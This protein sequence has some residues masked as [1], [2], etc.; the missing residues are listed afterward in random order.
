M[1]TIRIK[2]KLWE[3]KETALFH[4]AAVLRG[5]NRKQLSQPPAVGLVQ[6]I[7]IGQCSSN[8]KRD[9]EPPTNVAIFHGPGNC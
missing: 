3:G 1:P 8:K 9:G 2:P 7:G 6:P 4:R 5:K